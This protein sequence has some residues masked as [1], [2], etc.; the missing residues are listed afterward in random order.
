MQTICCLLYTSNQHTAH[1]N[2]E[3]VG[4]CAADVNREN[5]HQVHHEKEDRDAEPAVQNNLVDLIG[6]GRAHVT[7]VVQHLFADRAD[8]LIAGIGNSD[9]QV[10]AIVLNRTL[11]FQQIVR[12]IR[13]QFRSEFRV[14]EHLRGRPAGDVYKRQ[15]GRLLKEPDGSVIIQ[16]DNPAYPVRTFSESDFSSL[17]TVIGP[18]VLRTGSKF[19]ARGLLV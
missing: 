19:M 2:I 15:L 6:G 7:L 16:F 3:E 8:E 12:D 11:Q 18:V 10:F 13:G 9:I 14:F 17:I 1:E 5:E 4:K